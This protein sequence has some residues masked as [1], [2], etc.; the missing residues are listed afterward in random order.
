[1]ENV[2]IR[3][4][5]SILTVLRHLN[6]KPWFALAEFVDNAVASYFTHRDAIAAIDGAASKLRVDISIDQ[7][8]PAI[9]TI[10]DNAAGIGLADYPR[11][12]RPAAAPLDRS[13]LS[14][15]GMGMKSAACWFSP[16]WSVRTSA[17]GEAVERTV[18]FDIDKIVNDDINELMVEEAPA[19]VHA[20]F[21]EIML[22]DLH[23][24]PVGR[25]LGKI[26]DHL[27][28]IYR[29]FLREGSLRLVVGGSVLNSTTPDVLNTAYFE[30]P[31]AEPVM[32][33]KDI[34]FDLGQNMRVEGFAA[35]RAV[36]SVSDAGFALFRRRRLIQGSGDEGYRPELIFGKSN[37]YAFQ[38]LFG[39]LHL[40]GFEVAQT[41]DGIKWDENET[42]FLELLKEYL[43]APPLPLL[44]Q[45]RGYRARP[46]PAPVSPT[47]RSAVSRTASA[48]SSPR[49]AP[50][51]TA[52]PPEADVSPPA[53]L[54]ESEGESAAETV[55]VT[56][57]GRAWR[58]KIE[59]LND[60]GASQWLEL[61]DA[62]SVTSSGGPR[63]LHI[64][65]S[66]T[67]AF[68]V[69]F[70]GAD[71]DGL[72]P[73]IRMGTALAIAEILAR[74]SGVRQAGAIRRNFNDVLAAIFAA[75]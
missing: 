10:R 15:F 66:L 6:Y 20:H 22:L 63:D 70:A 48:L 13:G 67:H 43:D 11:A 55:E 27:T 26:R 41:K 24:P 16:K 17:L 9:L 61:A 29:L 58:V 37:S 47:A 50:P 68:T 40:H 52:P 2:N 33:R 71:E 75:P 36:A 54:P 14:E 1:M 3:P 12:F 51:R 42:P 57:G 30:T 72:E 65:I 5:V 49:S 59:L 62:G 56:F 31:D 60:P 18:T 73:L 4:G 23:R 28:D 35:L 46:R 44:K 7:G 74:E 69:R 25:T 45:A 21:T 39:E 32:W 53:S 64:R 19:D 38:R 8:P 34:S